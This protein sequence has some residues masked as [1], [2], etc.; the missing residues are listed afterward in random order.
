MKTRRDVTSGL[1]AGA[2]L[3]AS[4]ALAQNHRPMSDAAFD[5]AI[6][7]EH[8]NFEIIPVWPHNAPGLTRA[9]IEPVVT[10]RSTPPALRDRIAEHVLRPVLVM[11]R[12]E[13]PNGAALL[14]APGGAYI[15]LALDKECYESSARF[16]AAGVTTFVLLYRMP[17]DGHVAG[18]DAPLQDA[19]RALRLIRARA[20]EFGVDPA[21]TGVIGFSAGGHLAGSLSLRAETQ[22]Y[23][24]VD[25]IDDQSALPA[26]TVL[27]YPV[28]SMEAPFTHAGSRE[29]LLSASPSAEQMHAYSLEHLAHA[30]APPTQIISAAD[31]DAVPE[32]NSI[33]LHQALRAAGAPSELHIF[34]S[35]GHGFGTRGMVGKPGAIWPD[36]AL[37]WMR[38]H[39]AFA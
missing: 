27:L 28:V 34:E 21:R 17:G 32:Q 26:F 7:P 13:R 19:Q 36:L 14:M 3:A 24:R 37:N 35:G 10:E 9:H 29:A 5:A 39:G 38:A 6:A 31:D 23:S 16:N 2:T 33:V 1:A 12:P 8:A 25:A 18:P 22:T 20:A 11:L 30:G 4:P 15:R